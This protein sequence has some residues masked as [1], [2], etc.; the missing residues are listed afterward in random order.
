[1]SEY[2]SKIGFSDE[3]IFCLN[4]SVNSQILR[5]WGTERPIQ[6]RLAFTHSSSLMVWCT[7]SKGKAVGPYFFENGNVN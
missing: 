1:M 4:G 6:G 5:I 7:I 3:W 2:L